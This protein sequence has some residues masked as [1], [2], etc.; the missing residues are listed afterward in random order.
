MIVPAPMLDALAR[1]IA[2]QS[3]RWGSR[4]IIDPQAILDRS[5]DLVLAPPG[6]SS[7]NGSCRLL[8]AADGWIAVNLPRADDWALVLAWLESEIAVANWRDLEMAVVNRP[9]AELKERAVMLG[10]AV[11]IV[12]EV[13]SDN[14]PMTPALAMGEPRSRAGLP[15]VADLTSLWAGPLCAGLLARGGASVTRYESARRPDPSRY[16]APRFYA[17]LNQEKDHRLLDF[18]TSEGRAAVREAVSLAD[19]IVTSA[20][21]RAFSALGLDPADLFA[22]NPSLIWVA[23]TGHGWQGQSGQRVAFGDDAAAAGGLLQWTEAGE[24]RF[25]GDALADPLTGLAAASAAMR[26]WMDGGGVLIDVALARVAAFA[27]AAR[28][29]M[30]EAGN[31]DAVSRH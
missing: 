1:D 5:A 25:L 4:V 13:A 19:I 8:Q 21:P 31:C 14:D 7:P 9:I 20:R 11:A 27:A 3:A 18:Q 6:R 17:S 23:I 28:Y 29:D 16:A 30:C 15:V 10:L 24:P 12:G 2:C 26:A 22:A